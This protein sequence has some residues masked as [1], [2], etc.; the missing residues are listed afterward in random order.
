MEQK[1]PGF[2]WDYA[3]ISEADRIFPAKNL[4]SY[5]SKEKTTKTIL[6]PYPHYLFYKWDSYNDF[7]SFILNFKIPIRGKKRY[8]PEKSEVLY[9]NIH[10]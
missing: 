6:V 4:K 7:I 1:E 2:R 10:I 3:V 9:K 8:H 5:W